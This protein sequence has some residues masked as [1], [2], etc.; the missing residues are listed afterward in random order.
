LIREAGTGSFAKVYKVSKNDTGDIYA[1]KSLNKKF[2][3]KHKHL[4]YAISECRL[5][6]TLDHP[7]IIKLHYAF[8]TPSNLYLV[9]EYCPKGDLS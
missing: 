4:K 7:F 3:I 6:K 2:L 8:Q 5:L 1:M 9:L